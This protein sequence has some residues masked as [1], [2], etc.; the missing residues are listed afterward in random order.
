MMGFPWDG[1]T[2]RT[3]PSSKPYAHGLVQKTRPWWIEDFRHTIVPLIIQLEKLTET[4][5]IQWCII[6]GVRDITNYSL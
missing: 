1:H 6:I 5:L 3:S 4:I 2:S